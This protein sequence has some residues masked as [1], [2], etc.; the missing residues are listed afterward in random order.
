LLKQWVSSA[1]V[2]IMLVFCLDRNLHPLLTVC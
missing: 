2:E 1:R